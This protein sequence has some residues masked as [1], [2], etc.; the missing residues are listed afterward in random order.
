MSKNSHN[1]RPKNVH[2]Y[3][4][5]RFWEGSMFRDSGGGFQG[6]TEEGLLRVKE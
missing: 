2:I 6:K 4:H 1:K 5:I 3:K